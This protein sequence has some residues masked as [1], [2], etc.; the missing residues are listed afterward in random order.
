MIKT[1]LGREPVGTCAAAVPDTARQKPATV[2]HWLVRIVA[3][4]LMVCQEVMMSVAVW[5]SDAD[6]ST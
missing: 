3:C 2:N 1:T 4:L 5:T 6:V